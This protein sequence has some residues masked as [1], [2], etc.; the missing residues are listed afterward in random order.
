MATIK[1]AN[2]NP[3]G[4]AFFNDSESYLN[5]LTDSEMNVTGGIVWTVVAVTVV[6]GWNLWKGYNAG[7]CAR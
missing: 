5:E 7:R 3:V 2:L 4:S 1:I 6:V